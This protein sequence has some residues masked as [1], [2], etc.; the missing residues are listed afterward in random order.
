MRRVVF[1][2]LLGLAANAFAAPAPFAKPERRSDVERMRGEWEVVSQKRCYLMESRSGDVLVW[3]NVT[4]KTTARVTGERLRWYVRGSFLHE[5][6]I[7]THKGNVD[8]TDAQSGRTCLGLY[9]L[10]GDVL[11]IRTS[12][13]G[14]PDRPPSFDGDRPDEI[15]FVLRRKR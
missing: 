10:H 6:V 12:L 13:A 15:L 4:V 7:R 2:V 9:R 11:V 1:S 14:T 5:E 3:V 8:L